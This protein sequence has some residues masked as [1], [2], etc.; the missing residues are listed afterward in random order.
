MKRQFKSLTDGQNIDLIPYLKSKLAEADNIR[1]Y[2]GTDSQNIGSRT[3]YATVIVLHYG[4]SGGHVVYCKTSVPKILDKFTKLWNEVEDSV[5]LA[6]YLEENGIEKPA[7]ID[8]DFNPD[9]KYQ[10]NT[11]LRAALGY[12]E[13]LGYSPRCKPYAVSASYI[14]DRICK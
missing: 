10:S 14:A 9:P 2:V 4:N 8:L 3:V 5:S 12:V 11:V 6:Q 13:S 7:F 1:M